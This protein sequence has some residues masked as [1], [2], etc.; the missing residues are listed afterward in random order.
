M[1]EV[2]LAPLRILEIYLQYT[3]ELQQFWNTVQY[4]F[5]DKFE[6]IYCDLLLSEL[7]TEKKQLLNSILEQS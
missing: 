2:S 4:A 5:Y 3:N 1:K 6:T 7:D